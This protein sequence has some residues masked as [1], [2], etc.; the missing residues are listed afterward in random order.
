MKRGQK[1]EKA[2][3]TRELIYQR[4]LELFRSKSFESSTMRDIAE[5]CE[6]ATGAS[7]YYY[8]T[9]EHLILEFYRRSQAT[10]STFVDS[11]TIEKEDFPV[12]LRKLL[13]QRFESLRPDR[14]LVKVLS[15]VSMN[16]ESP[17]SPFSPSTSDLRDESILLHKRIIQGTNLKL[18]PDLE[19]RLPKFLWLFQMGLLFLWVH[20][21]SPH[22]KKTHQLMQRGISIV[23]HIIRLLRVPVVRNIFVSILDLIDTID[24]VILTKASTRS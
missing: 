19:K 22:Q 23:I 15:R 1:T 18:R 24:D 6:L 10:A 4:A 7:Y 9:K 12:R 20:D 17:L 8:Q 5:S 21:D 11:L 14:N 16:I 3:A 13:E 2:V